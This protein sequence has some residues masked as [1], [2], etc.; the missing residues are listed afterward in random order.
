M[1]NIRPFVLNLFL[2]FTLLFTACNGKKTVVITLK[3]PVDID[4]PDEAIV[5]QRSFLDSLTGSIPEGKVPCLIDEKGKIIPSQTDDLD[6]DGKWDELFTLL[7]FSPRGERKLEITFVSPE[8]LPDFSPRANIRFANYPEHRELDHADRLRTTDSPSTQKAFQMEGPAWENDKVAFR[9]YYDARNG[10][11]I[12]GKRVSRMVLDSV[13]LIPHSYHVLKDWGMDI[14]KVGNSLGAGAIALMVND[15]VFRVDLPEKG[16][17]ERVA[18]GPLRVIFRLGYY[19]WHAGGH[20]Y[21]ILDEISIW[22][23]TNFY[24]ARVSVKGVTGNESLITGIV[25]HCDSLHID[26]PNDKYIFF[27]THCNQAYEGEKLGMA[28][29]V[30]AEDFITTIQAPTSGE[31]I[32][33]TYMIDLKLHEDHPTEYLFYSGWEKQ[34]PRFAEAGYFHSLITRDAQ[35]LAHPIMI[36]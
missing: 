36:R 14:L 11:D 27:S 2:F 18:D 31:G 35:R 33:N 10:I 34:D 3:N 20:T 26:Q 13:G 17:F 19:G 21:D 12:F 22:G 25:R 8:K 6:R 24:K 5:L 15:S 23:G 9:N 28:I 4:R 7:D 1:K 32:V 16:T 30:K 29:L